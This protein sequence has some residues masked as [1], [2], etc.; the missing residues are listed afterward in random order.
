MSIQAYGCQFYVKYM[1]NMERCIANEIYE[2]TSYCNVVIC[3]ARSAGAVRLR[4]ADANC[5]AHTGTYRYPGTSGRA[6]DGQ[7]ERRYAAVPDTR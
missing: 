3:I 2:T 6:A 1:L 4:I 5:D 7:R